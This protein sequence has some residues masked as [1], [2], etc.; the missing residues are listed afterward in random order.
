VI[1][2]ILLLLVVIVATAAA[3]VADAARRKARSARLAA[4]AGEW[5]MG[6]TSD[7]RFQ[8]TPRVAAAFPT[9][10]AA[11]IVL[12]DLVYGREPAGCFRYFFTVEFTT[13]VLRTKHRRVRAAMLVETGRDPAAAGARS[14]GD[15]PVYSPITL[16]PADLPLAEQYQSLH[17]AHCAAPAPT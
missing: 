5:H 16:A 2:P 9:P 10:G 15:S 14:A 3:V 11:D 17:R 13:G 12:R 1:P 4:L 6:F 7:D 8:L